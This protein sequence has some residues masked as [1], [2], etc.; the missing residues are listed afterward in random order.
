ME[1]FIDH[2]ERKVAHLID[3]VCSETKIIDLP[4][5]DYLIA[6]ENGSVIVERKSVHDFISSVRSNRLWDQ[7]LRLMKAEEV[8][9]YRIRRR[10]L[11]IQGSVEKYLRSIARYS[12]RDTEVFWSQI[13]GAFL[14][15][16]YVYNTPIIFIE[17][18]EDLR[19][20]F[21]TLIRREEKG[22]NDKLPEAKWYMKRVRSDLPTKDRKRYILSSLPFIGETLARNLLEHFGTISNVANASVDELQEVPKIGK[23]KAEIIYKM[24]H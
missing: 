15:I 20:F 6:S 1:L 2:R 16:L 23:K 18:D 14:E 3:D 8:L 13:M 11:L 9:G 17:K 4:L 5:G 22:L 21:K 10:I 24:F 19:P 7:L 12:I